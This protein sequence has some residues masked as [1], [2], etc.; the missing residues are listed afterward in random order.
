[1]TARLL[2]SQMVFGYLH[3]QIHHPENAVFGMDEQTPPIRMELQHVDRDAPEVA[4]VNFLPRAR[5][6]TKPLLLCE[7]SLKPRFNEST[8][9]SII[10]YDNIRFWY[11]LYRPLL[12]WMLALFAAVYWGLPHI[13]DA[14][15]VGRE[16]SSSC[17]H[18]ARQKEII[19]NGIKIT[20]LL[21][22]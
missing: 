19:I 18:R 15:V 3:P 4:L 8:P 11:H 10:F 13:D 5:Q 7:Q 6:N 21:T 17:L 22:W 1:M 16:H 2:W 20:S 9:C 12:A 14:C